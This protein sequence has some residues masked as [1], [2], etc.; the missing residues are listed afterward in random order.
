MQA[1]F[2]DATIPRAIL[3]IAH[4][5]HGPTIDSGTYNYYIF[6]Y[7]GSCQYCSSSPPIYDNRDGINARDDTLRCIVICLVAIH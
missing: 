2:H 6:S 1:L 4:E 7:I 5:D 3:A